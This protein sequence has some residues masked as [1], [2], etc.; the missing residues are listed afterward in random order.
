VQET[1]IETTKRIMLHCGT[2]CISKSIIQKA[3]RLYSNSSD[4]ND[5]MKLLNMNH[6]GG[7]R[8]SYRNGTITGGY[9]KCYCGSVSKTKIPI[10]IDYCNC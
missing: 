8:L 6:I 2:K 4:I 10:S 9:D 3:K 1:S 5:F 7:G